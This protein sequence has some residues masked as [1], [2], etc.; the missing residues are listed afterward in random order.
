MGLQYAQGAEFESKLTAYILPYI[1]KAIP[2]L[3][4]EL[5]HLYTEK[6]RVETIERILLAQTAS[7]EKDSKFVN[8]EK[9]ESPTCLLWTYM[10]LAQHFDKVGQLDTAVEYINKAIS[11]TPTLIELYLVKAKIFKHKFNHAAAFEFAE[12]VH[13]RF[14]DTFL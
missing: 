13:H 12:K 1:R 8:S 5:K 9:V 10:L 3:F 2:S 6:A 7:L 11:H 4:S 14:T